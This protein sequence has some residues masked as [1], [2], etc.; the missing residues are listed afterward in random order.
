MSVQSAKEH[1][2][3]IAAAKDLGFTVWDFAELFTDINQFS[4]S[5][6]QAETLAEKEKEKLFKISG[7]KRLKNVL[8]R[9]DIDVETREGVLTLWKYLRDGNADNSIRD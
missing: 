8:D 7:I 3:F 9:H 2:G 1:E 4:A 5:L 6:L